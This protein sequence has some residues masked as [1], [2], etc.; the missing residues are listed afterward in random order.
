MKFK[1][2]YITP[3]GS[4]EVQ[5]DM[6]NLTYR[7]RAPEANWTAKNITYNTVDVYNKNTY[8]FSNKSLYINKQGRLYFKGKPKG[9]MGD[10][11]TYFIDELVKVV[12]DE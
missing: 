6:N 7:T 9:Y 1:P 12:E 3:D 10:T 11:K 8:S 2:N 5:I 4:F